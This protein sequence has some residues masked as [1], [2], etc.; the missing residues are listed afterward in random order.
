MPH[1]LLAAVLLG[2]AAAAASGPAL[3]AT[4]AAAGTVASGSARS[5]V[6]PPVFA[7]R[8]ESVLLRDPTP[9]LTPRALAKPITMHVLREDNDVAVEDSSG[10]GDDDD[11]IDGDPV[12]VSPNAQPVIYDVLKP[13]W[14]FSSALWTSNASI[15]GLLT[16]LPA[17]FQVSFIADVANNTAAKAATAALRARIQARASVLNKTGAVGQMV[18]SSQSL[19]A[20][21]KTQPWIAQLLCEWPTILDQMHVTIRTAESGPHGDED[22]EDGDGEQ[23]SRASAA[24]AAAA[25]AVT[26]TAVAA[27]P[28]LNSFF[29]WLGWGFWPSSALGNASYR[30]VPVDSAT[31]STPIAANLSGSVALVFDTGA[32]DAYGMVKRAALASAAA[33]LVVSR[34]RDLQLLQCVGDAQCNDQSFGLPAV[35][36]SNETGQLLL[37][38]SPQGAF[39]SFSTIEQC[40]TSFGVNATGALVQTW[41]GSGLGN[42]TDQTCVRCAPPARPTPQQ[43]QQQQ[44][45]QQQ[46]QQQPQQQQQQQQHP[47]FMRSPSSHVLAH[48]SRCHCVSNCVRGTANLFFTRMHACTPA[49]DDPKHKHTPHTKHQIRYGNPGDIAAKQYPSFSFLGYAAQSL[50][51]LA[52]VAAANDGQPGAV[53]TKVFDSTPMRPMVGNCYNAA[54][55]GCGPTAVVAVPPASGRAAGTGGVAAS[56]PYERVV[57]DYQ[58]RCNTS[59]DV[60]CPQWDHVVQL[61]ACCST[62][63]LSSESGAAA[64]TSSSNT[65]NAQNGFELGRWIT[66]FGRGIGRWR[67]DVTRWL[68]LLR[69]GRANN[70]NTLNSYCNLTLCVRE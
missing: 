46:Q 21:S 30:V 38:S 29:D 3:V 66:P 2:T 68:P 8:T 23:S 18:F 36:V 55:W 14:G 50:N 44:Q 11:A 1:T 69:A 20:M 43:Q 39:V 47:K 7:H 45:P 19:K 9:E 33:V 35:S 32:C 12:W 28:Y 16:K 52:G 41:G 60:S 6:M 59:A 56:P 57:L 34:T 58:L 70:A 49:D 54:P 26:T 51:Y 37:L 42:P 53:V 24:A 40:G 17:N 31:C 64:T 62:T 13:A 15:D 61:K 27:V 10:D 4:T 5:R 67:T 48:R 65:C 22:G 25:A 63:A